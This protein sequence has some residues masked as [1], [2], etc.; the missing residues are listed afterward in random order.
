MPQNDA[1]WNELAAQMGMSLDNDAADEQAVDSP[2]P[3]RA[4][5][6]TRCCT[7]PLNM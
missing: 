4:S 1:Q 6:F 7:T 3:G 5:G 2:M